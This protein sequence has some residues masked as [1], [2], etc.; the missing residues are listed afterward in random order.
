MTEEGMIQAAFDNLLQHYLN[1]NHR[2]KTDV[3]L[4]AYNFALHA[5]QNVRRSSGEHYMIHPIAVATLVSQE[6]GLGSTYIW[7]GLLHDVVEVSDSTTEDI[8]VIFGTKV[9]QIGEGLT[10]IAGGIFGD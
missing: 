1:S 6:M 2:K 3:L 8:N 10:K 9:A 7:A 4:K 5:T